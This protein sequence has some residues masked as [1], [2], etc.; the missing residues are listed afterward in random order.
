MKLFI[1]GISILAATTFSG[2]A[3]ALTQPVVGG[4]NIPASASLHIPLPAGVT[5]S[6]SNGY[7]AGYH[8]GVDGTTTMNQYYALDFYIDGIAN[9]YAALAVA[10]GIVKLA[11]WAPSG[12]STCG[13]WVVVE[14]NFGDGHRYV[15]NYCHLYSIAVSVGQSVAAGQKLGMVGCSSDLGNYCDP[16]RWGPHLHL[17]MQRDPTISGGSYGGNAA[18]PEAI[19]GYQNIVY[20]MYVTSKNTGTNFSLGEQGTVHGLGNKCVD[21]Y[22]AST[23]DGTKIQTWDCLAGI[24]DQQWR[25]SSARELRNALADKCMGIAGGVSSDGKPIVEWNCNGNGDQK[26]TYQNMELVASSGKC[27]DVPNSNF[28]SGQ[29]VQLYDC[30][31]TAAQKW[32]YDPTTQM[33]H[34]AQNNMCLDARA[35]GTA[36]GTVAQIWTCNTSATNQRWAQG[37]GG[38]VPQH[39]A[40][41][42]LDV[43][44]GGTANGT[45]IQ[46]WDCNGTNPQRFALRGKIEN[47]LGKCLDIPNSNAINGQQLQIYTCNGTGAQKWTVWSPH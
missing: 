30:N 8:V 17:S 29:A 41:K 23:N 4:V 18:V 42:C 20:G 9:K 6:I 15:S 46:I 10:P 7:G 38:F 1:E 3:S 11:G 25:I 21:I 36:N 13:Q 33:L 19:D 44:A 37:R 47:Y 22:A 40:T 32:T 45:K 35:Y 34:A 16:S 14:H 31:G 27:I 5:A 2:A 28:V 39:V 24:K 43:S 26:W 12:W